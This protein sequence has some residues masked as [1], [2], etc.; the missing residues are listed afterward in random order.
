M[1]AFTSSPYL[2]RARE[3]DQPVEFTGG[4]VEGP[5]LVDDAFP[6]E[7]GEEVDGGRRD[8]IANLGYKSAEVDASAAAGRLE[9]ES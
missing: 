7:F 4:E 3:H 1:Q 6:F 5:G 8:L 9:L 2:G